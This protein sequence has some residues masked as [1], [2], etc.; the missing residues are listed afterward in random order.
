LNDKQ[1]KIARAALA[2][3]RGI[4][5][6]SELARELGITPQ[7]V[8]KWAVCPPARVLDVE[9]I[10]AVPRHQLRPDLYPE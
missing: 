9:R 3:A 7:A 4:V 2:M 10:A 1:Q 5:G 6:T 8:S